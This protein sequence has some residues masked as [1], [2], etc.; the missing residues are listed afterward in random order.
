MGGDLGGFLSLTF[1]RVGSRVLGGVR[2][3]GC[4]GVFGGRWLERRWHR[5]NGPRWRI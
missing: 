3:S 5:L 1:G 2:G 4:A